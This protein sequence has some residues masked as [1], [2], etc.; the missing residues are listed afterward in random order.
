MTASN[1]KNW[2][3]SLYHYKQ[4]TSNKQYKNSPASTM[5]MNYKINFNMVR[6][7]FE[8]FWLNL[9]VQLNALQN[10][11]KKGKNEMKVLICL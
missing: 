8:F 1:R 4:K 7:Y 2:P 3:F 11:Q 10:A 6:N 5:H 9:K